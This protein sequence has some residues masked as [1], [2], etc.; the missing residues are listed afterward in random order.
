MRKGVEGEQRKLFLKPIARRSLRDIP[1]AT[2]LASKGLSTES[3]AKG[4]SGEE[5][6]S[7]RKNERTT[8]GRRDECSS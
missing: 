1:E 8:S 7:G 2:N 5:V 3:K 4:N 6:F